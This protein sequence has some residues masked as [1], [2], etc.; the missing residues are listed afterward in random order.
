M[1]GQSSP[2]LEVYISGSGTYLGANDEAL[3]VLGYTADELQ[4][5]P[6]GTL[7]GSSPEAARR[8]WLAYVDDGLVI[9]AHANIRLWT[10]AGRQIAT[11]FIGSERLDAGRW[12]SRYRLLTG[13]AV[14]TDQPFVLQTLLAQW[15]ELERRLAALVGDPI[16]QSEIEA[17]LAEVRALYQSEEQRRRELGDAL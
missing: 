1:V 3:E 13:T 6:F 14:A 2:T 12:V 4:T 15:R 5:L 9:P 16:A 8:L 7:S 11:R 10:R 17:H